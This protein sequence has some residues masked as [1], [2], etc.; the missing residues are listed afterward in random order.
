MGLVLMAS[1]LVFL[2]ARS[3]GAPRNVV[4]PE[5]DGEEEVEG[6]ESWLLDDMVDVPPDREV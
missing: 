3:R 6:E 4:G 5:G 1:L 2:R